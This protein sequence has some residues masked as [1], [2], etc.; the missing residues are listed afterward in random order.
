MSMRWSIGSMRI[1]WRLAAISGGNC[2]GAERRAI[3][4]FAA[5]SLSSSVVA[6]HRLSAM[7]CHSARKLKGDLQGKAVNPIPGQQS[8]RHQVSSRIV[9]LFAARV[10]ALHANGDGIGP[11]AQ[12]D[13]LQET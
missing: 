9:I 5:L 6:K 1:R 12:Q 3:G 7:T 11:S 4:G 2:I 8:D 13:T 10:T